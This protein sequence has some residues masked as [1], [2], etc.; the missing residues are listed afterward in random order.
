[1]LVLFLSGFNETTTPCWSLAPH[2]GPGYRSATTDHGCRATRFAGQQLATL[3]VGQSWLATCRPGLGEPGAAS[4]HDPGTPMGEPHTRTAWMSPSRW[5]DR[6][7]AE[8]VWVGAWP[9]SVCR[10]RFPASRAGAGSDT[11][12]SSSTRVMTRTPGMWLTVRRTFCTA[13]VPSHG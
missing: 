2:R 6:S 4:G 7:G 1:M 3:P 10:P 12:A 11:Q 5:Q 9:V 13:A 8:P